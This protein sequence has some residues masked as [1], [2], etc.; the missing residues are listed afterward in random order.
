MAKINS[1]EFRTNMTDVLEKQLV[2]GATVGFFED[3][4]LR[5][6]FVGAKTVLIP[7]MDMSSLGDYDRDNGFVTGAINISSE[8]F[9]LSQDRARSFQLDREDNDET[10]VADLA[11]EVL[12]EF[13]R[14]KVVPE[15]DAYVLSKLGGYA[16]T[17]G[18]TVEGDPD[19]EAYAM[20][21]QAVSNIREEVGFDEELV[22][23]A[24]NA[25]LKSLSASPEIARQITVSDFKKGAVHTQVRT[26]DDIKLLP[27]P[28]S[29]MKTQYDFYDGTTGGQEDGGFVPTAEAKDI[30]FI[31]LP[32]KAVSLVKKSETLRTFSP[33]E[34]LK[35]DA[36]KFDYRLYYDA[37]IKTTMRSAVY[38]FVRG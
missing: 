13:V 37:F 19:T 25:F 23:F 24:D 38:A 20:F 8:P 4:A 11:G 18:Q 12:T 6:K 1:L 9:T 2:Q 35:A 22:C 5:A 10:G 26:L 30:G 14:T 15:V 17:N 28:L 7:T 3:N 36:W 16:A 34:N 21:A 32:K 33:E 27:V 29:R 31:I